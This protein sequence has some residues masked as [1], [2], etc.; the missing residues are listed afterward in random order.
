M[1]EQNNSLVWIDLKYAYS[2][3]TVQYSMLYRELSIDWYL[4]S[5]CEYILWQ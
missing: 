1:E 3:C 2:T 4:I 5:S